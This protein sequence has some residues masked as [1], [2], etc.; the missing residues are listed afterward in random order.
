MDEESPA[1]ED[2]ADRVPKRR[3]SKLHGRRGLTQKITNYKLS[4]ILVNKHVF[5]AGPERNSD[6]NLLS[7]EENIKRFVFMITSPLHPA[8]MS[9]YKCFTLDTHG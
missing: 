9:S 8:R 4:I 6:C 5:R 3:L 7:E 1:Y 2:G